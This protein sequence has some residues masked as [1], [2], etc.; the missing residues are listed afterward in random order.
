MLMYAIEKAKGNEVEVLFLSE[1]KDDAIK[2]GD[3]LFK[4]IPREQGLLSL[5]R[6][7]YVD[8]VRQG[9]RYELIDSWC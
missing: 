1:N 8:G 9:S 5:I 6:A 7:D 2:K 4:E 3:E